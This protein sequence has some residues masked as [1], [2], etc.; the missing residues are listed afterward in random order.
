MGD[1][2]IFAGLAGEDEEEFAAVVVADGVE[3]GVE[4]LELVVVEGQADEMAAERGE[5]GEERGEGCLHVW[6]KVH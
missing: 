5:V 3:D 4:G 2:F 6:M 1:G